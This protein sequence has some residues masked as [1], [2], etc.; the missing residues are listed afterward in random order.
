[1]PENE[2]EY[3]IFTQNLKE[4]RPHGTLMCGYEDTTENCS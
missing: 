3:N 1:M 4:K 2:K